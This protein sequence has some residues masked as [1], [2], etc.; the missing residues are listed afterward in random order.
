MFNN[1]LIKF[2]AGYIVAKE[3]GCSGKKKS[4]GPGESVDEKKPVFFR[5]RN[6]EVGFSRGQ[7]RNKS[8][9]KARE[10]I[11]TAMEGLRK[12]SGERENETE[13]RSFDVRDFL[14]TLARIFREDRGKDDDEIVG[15]PTLG[16]HEFGILRG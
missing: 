9:F 2:A 5:S 6:P 8:K 14:K 13:S 4:A 16:S 12:I 3:A 7:W 1:E 10:P 15:A 11:S